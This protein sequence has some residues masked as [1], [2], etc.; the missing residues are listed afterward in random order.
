MVWCQGI[1]PT[2]AMTEWSSDVGS[3]MGLANQ[4]AT[5]NQ[6]VNSITEMV[7][8]PSEWTAV[9]KYEV[10]AYFTLRDPLA[11][12]LIGCVSKI[13]SDHANHISL[14]QLLGRSQQTERL[15]LDACPL[16]RVE[17]VSRQMCSYGRNPPAC[18][19]SF[20]MDTREWQ[21]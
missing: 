17:E 9:T 14:Q 21:S 1:I 16:Q 2:I 11:N 6:A 18:S 4:D 5:S 8:F 19:L 15:T 13:S 10:A 3:A 12:M 7:L 20:L